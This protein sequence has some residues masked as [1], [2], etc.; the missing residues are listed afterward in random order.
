MMKKFREI[1]LF[2]SPK[3]DLL[4]WTIES[5]SHDIDE[6]KRFLTMINFPK[7]DSTGY[8]I[9][10]KA[11]NKEEALQNHVKMLKKFAINRLN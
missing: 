3:E 7:N 4:I 9:V 1:S 8:K 10:A 5:L 11:E 6:P 2:A